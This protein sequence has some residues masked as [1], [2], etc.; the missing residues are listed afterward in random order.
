MISDRTGVSGV[1]G[2]EN[3]RIQAACAQVAFAPR[4]LGCVG[5]RT[6]SW[7]AE[8]VSPMASAAKGLFRPPDWGPWG[9]KSHM[10][11]TAQQQT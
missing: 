1:L 6:A 11:T 4:A 10:A 2:A 8:A 7:A 9:R 3:L 5:R